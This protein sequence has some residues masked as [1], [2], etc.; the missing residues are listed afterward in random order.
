[1][2]AFTVDKKGI[3]NREQTLK[4]CQQKQREDLEASEQK[5]QQDSQAFNI[6]Q[7]KGS[8]R[9]KQEITPSPDSDSSDNEDD[10]H[11]N[12]QTFSTSNDSAAVS[13]RD[14]LFML[15]AT[16]DGADEVQDQIFQNSSGI[17][18]SARLQAK[19]GK[20]SNARKC[21]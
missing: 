10:A 21:T 15:S 7:S 12:A 19:R 17:R 16:L 20:E 11:C 13:H 2:S 4:N 8:R 6:S 18:T 1:M 3:E 5:V 14:R 9:K